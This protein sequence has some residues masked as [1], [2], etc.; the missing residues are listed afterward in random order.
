M[1]MERKGTDVYI[2]IDERY[3]PPVAVTV[4]DYKELNPEG[5]FIDTGCEILEERPDGRQDVVAVNQ[6]RL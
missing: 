5:M 6:N 2:N 4:S 3:G 1:E